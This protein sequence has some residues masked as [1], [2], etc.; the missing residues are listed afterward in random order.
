MIVKLDG[1][2]RVDTPRALG[3]VSRWVEPKKPGHQPFRK[4][5][6]VNS[7][8]VLDKWPTSRRRLK[9]LTPA[10]SNRIGT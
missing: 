7:R 10:K 6:Q 4:A 5:I 8:W 2:M 9:L 3:T 1:A